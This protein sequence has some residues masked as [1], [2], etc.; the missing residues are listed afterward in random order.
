MDL[1]SNGFEAMLAS[2]KTAE[3]AD[4]AISLVRQIDALKVALESVYRFREES[5]KY[6]VLE[7]NALLRVVELGGVSDL[8]APHKK[9]AEWLRTLTA[10]ELD[11]YISKC[12]NGITIDEIFKYEI[13]L[14][15]KTDRALKSIK[16]SEER[17][18]AELE[19][20]GMADLKAFSGV[21]R[22]ELRGVYGVNPNDLIDGTRNRMLKAGAVGVGHNSGIYV[23]PKRAKSDDVFSAICVR[24]Q[25]IAADIAAVRAL[26]NT[27][28]KRPSFE[29]IANIAREEDVMLDEY[30]YD[31]Q[32]IGF[33]ET[34]GVF[35]PKSGAE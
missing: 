8:R 12:A 31:A 24:Y 29:E 21:V 1:T 7:A 18:L 2:V 23:I 9:T 25:S 33:M 30:C 28:G 14:K 35:A 19:E 27:C 17:F 16:A 3:S 5:I 20:N 4:K 11:H 26:A 15:N 32:I 10:Q 22:Q 6:A 13:E 34:I